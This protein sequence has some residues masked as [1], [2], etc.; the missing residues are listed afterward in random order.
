MRNP[1][2]NSAMFYT[3]EWV[4]EW[5]S[6]WICTT[7]GVVFFRENSTLSLRPVMDRLATLVPRMKLF[8]CC[9]VYLSCNDQHILYVEEDM[10]LVYINGYYRTF[11]SQYSLRETV[12]SFGRMWTEVGMPVSSGLGRDRLSERRGVWWNPQEKNYLQTSFSCL[13]SGMKHTTT[14]T[15]R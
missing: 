6:D 5:G 14:N 10:G 9:L 13:S 8:S 2:V 12:C 15:Q 4:S 3:S 7:I 11:L 1:T